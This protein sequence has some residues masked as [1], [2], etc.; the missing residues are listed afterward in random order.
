MAQGRDE[1]NWRGGH[2]HIGRCWR[3]DRD[4]RNVTISTGI[5]GSSSGK[6]GDITIT[7]GNTVATGP[8][9]VTVTTGAGT[10]GVGSAA[11]NIKTG[12]TTAGG[13]GALS[14]GTGTGTNSVASGA[15]SITTGNVTGGTASSGAITIAT[16][17]R[18]G[19]GA[20]SSISITANAGV[21]TGVGGNINI[22][23]G[24]GIGSRR[25]HCPDMGTGS[26][27]GVI[28][29]VNCNVA[30]GSVAT[31][32]S[33]VGPTGAATTIQGWLCNSNRR[34]RPLHAFW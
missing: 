18:L 28:N 24:N 32:M 4:W 29:F 8:G 15:V 11:I 20:G 6:S 17:T 1:C 27:Q 19:T 22:T 21:T 31:A 5:G 16:G 12:D 9:T 3:Y 26:T 23:A 14:L 13:S 7:T 10:S 25:E 2:D 34:R 30:N 33:S